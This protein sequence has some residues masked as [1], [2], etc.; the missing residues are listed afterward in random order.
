[1]ENVCCETPAQIIDKVITLSML[2]EGSKGMIISYLM[3]CEDSHSCRFVRR[4]KEMG[5]HKGA[6]FE[7]LKNSGNGEISIACEGAT[8]ALGRGMAEKINVE[9]SNGSI[10]ANTTFSRFCRKFG[11]KC[12]P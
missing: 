3:N 4:L 6:K 10:I 8:L 2:E 9:I 11:I 5:L 7:V 12:R 1:M